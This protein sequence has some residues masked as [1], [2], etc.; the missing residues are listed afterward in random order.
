M[1]ISKFY[2]HA[3]IVDWW[4]GIISTTISQFIIVFGIYVSILVQ[5][6]D[7]DTFNLSKLRT[8]IVKY[9]DVPSLTL[10]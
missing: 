2:L 9:T 5:G 7:G 6:E 4:N 1:S 3:F 8:S 10:D